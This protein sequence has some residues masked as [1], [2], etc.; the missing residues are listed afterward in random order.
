M[1]PPERFERSFTDSKSGVLPVRRRGN[2]LDALQG[3]E[4]RLNG[5]EPRLLPLEERAIILHLPHQDELILEEDY[6]A[7]TLHSALLEYIHH[8]H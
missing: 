7:Y 6:Q 1:D 2:K 8:G 4:P 5:S 3:F